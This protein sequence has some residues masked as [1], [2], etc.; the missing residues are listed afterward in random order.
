M[1]FFYFFE[2]DQSEWYKEVG[3][4]IYDYNVES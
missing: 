3:I 2:K 1:P 4:E